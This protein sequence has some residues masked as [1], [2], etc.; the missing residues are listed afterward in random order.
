MNDDRLNE[1]LKSTSVPERPR[2][3]WEQFPAQVTREL[4]RNA[5]GSARVSPPT[6]PFFFRPA[7]GFALCIAVACLLVGF[8]IGRR[9]GSS[10]GRI[11]TTFAQAQQYYREIAQLFPNQ[12]RAIVF[13]QTGTHLVLAD[14][15]D[16][17]AASPV[18]MKICGPKGCQGIVTFSGQQIRVNG[19]PMDVLVGP[20]D[21]VI[22]AGPD[23]I[24]SSKQAGNQIGEYRIQAE[25]LHPQ[26]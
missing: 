22:L 3:Y 20:M 13:D 14:R 6:R 18:F 12:V 16:V 11:D 9:G 8:W 1:L 21:E 10:G 19:K 25:A 7:F 5:H 26:L 23:S 4:R 2:E 24:W 15:A 17:P